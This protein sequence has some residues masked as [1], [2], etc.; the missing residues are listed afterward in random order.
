M[1]D[2]PRSYTSACSNSVLLMMSHTYAC[3]SMR[4]QA[5]SSL[6]MY[7]YVCMYDGTKKWMNHKANKQKHYIVLLCVCMCNSLYIRSLG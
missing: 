5:L 3:T 7:T 1:F 6:A 4:A 2:T